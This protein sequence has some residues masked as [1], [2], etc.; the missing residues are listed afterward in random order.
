MIVD[1]VDPSIDNTIECDKRQQLLIFSFAAIPYIHDEDMMTFLNN[2]FQSIQKAWNETHSRWGKAGLV[3]FYTF[4][5]AEL[6]W[7]IQILV[8]PLLF[9]PCFD[10]HASDSE[11]LLSEALMRQLNLFAMGLVLYAYS[12]GLEL[13]NVSMVLT[14]FAMNTIGFFV[15]MIA[16]A[17]LHQFTTC[18]TEHEKLVKTKFTFLLL[19]LAACIC[20]IDERSGAIVD[21]AK[22]RRKEHHQQEQGQEHPHHHHHSTPKPP[23]FNPIYYVK[24]E[25]ENTHSMWGKAS[26]VLFYSF[27]W[28]H[29]LTAL[30]VIVFDPWAGHSCLRDSATAGDTLL[31]Q[32]YVREGGIYAVA[33][34]L[35]AGRNGARLLNVC[36]V[37]IV[38]AT[39]LALF[40]YNL[41]IPLV[42]LD[43]FSVC[44]SDFASLE[45]IAAQCA[46][47]AW[48]VLALL[49]SLVD[50]RTKSAPTTTNDDPDESA[51]ETTPL[52]V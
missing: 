5:W 52:V 47:V 29:I 19:I 50:A 18:R 30:V 10:A 28:F 32:T 12:G 17:Q 33:F 6:V 3:L 31:T 16:Y 11:S 24:R 36:G 48:I 39:W 14:I 7:G 1:T 34:F 41:V 26:I 46:V 2:P 22:Q 4:V 38:Y 8:S 9:F 23:P 49:F 13:W 43:R 20:A 51:N 40:R 15:L 45:N 37:F 35:Y 27:L 25:W 42:A 21:K 44:A